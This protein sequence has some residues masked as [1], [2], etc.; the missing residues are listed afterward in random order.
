MSFIINI[1]QAV[2]M[3]AKHDGKEDVLNRKLKELEEREAKRRE[4]ER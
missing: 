3:S 1:E 2:T 4:E